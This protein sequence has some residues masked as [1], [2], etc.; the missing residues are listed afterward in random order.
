MVLYSECVFARLFIKSI[1]CFIISS[2]FLYILYV[3]I[4]VVSVSTVSCFIL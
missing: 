2:C 1:F 4:F 3:C